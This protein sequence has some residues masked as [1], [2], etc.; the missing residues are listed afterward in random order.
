M[1]QARKHEKTWVEPGPA[2]L[3]ADLERMRYPEALTNRRILNRSPWS[4]GPT[5]GSV[6]KIAKDLVVH[7]FPLVGSCNLDYGKT[8][9]KS[10]G[11]DAHAIQLDVTN[12]ASIVAAAELIRKQI[13]RL[14][15]LVNDAGISHTGKA[16]TPSPAVRGCLATFQS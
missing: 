9:E 1:P 12:Q 7:R 15:L 14:D 3:I 13:G 11:A 4:L 5:K 2:C 10:V 16:G 8:P 6:F